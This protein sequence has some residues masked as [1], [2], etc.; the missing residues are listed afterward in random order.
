MATARLFGD[1]FVPDAGCWKRNGSYLNKFNNQ[2][3][4]LWLLHAGSASGRQ[5]YWP[6]FIAMHRPRVA[7]N[8]VAIRPA[9][10][11][12]TSTHRR[13]WYTVR[14]KCPSHRSGFGVPGAFALGVEL[15][16]G[17]G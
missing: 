16:L 10:A 3:Y 5:S 1:G 14:R 6:Y 12:R 8:E 11:R 2:F 7:S 13:Y 9:R 4:Q 15:A 17:R